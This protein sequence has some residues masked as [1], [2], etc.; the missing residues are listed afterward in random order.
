MV[1][2]AGSSIISAL[3][4]GSG[5]N[6]TSLVAD[7][8]SA[9]RGPKQTAI[10]DKQSLNNA[11]VSAMASAISSMSTFSTTLSTMLKDPTYTG[12]PASA[13]PSIV[14]VS[15]LST[16]KPAGLPA[17]I[18]VQQLAQAQVLKS[19]TLA[20]SGTA[21]GQGS[22]TLTTA[23]GAHKITIGEGNDSLAG[24]AQAI[25][26]SGAG[27]T[28]TVMSDASGSRLVLKGATGA[29]NSFT[30]T[31]EA[32]DTASAD[33]ERFT[34]GSGSNG[35]MASTQDARNAIIRLDGVEMQFA[36]NTVKE[37]LPNVQID[38]NKAAPGTKVALGM[39]T[40]AT[41]IQDMLKDFVSGYNSMRGALNSV[42]AGGQNASA[43]GALAGD[44]SIREM[45]S[46]LSELTTTELLSDG[47]YKSLSDIGVKTNR[48]GTLTLDTDRLKAV[49]ETS[50][51]IVERMINPATSTDDNPGLA[52]IVTDVNDRLQGKDGALTVAK[53]KYDALT[54]SYA[55]QME[56]LNTQMENYEE[57]MTAVYARLGT[58][59]NT[60]K[61]TQS[62]MEQQISVWTNKE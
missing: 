22:L 19:E 37:A 53:A 55:E 30:L 12:K 23:S 32:D 28:A 1:S 16:G 17:Q 39:D 42:S 35:T 60:I 36:T 48:D 44:S 20:T 38:L 56:K 24:L 26:D 58:Q 5:L 9:A 51:D 14:S 43:T 29:D 7:L 52:K 47:P 54:K 34:F 59:L 57:R 46:R 2:S 4:G 40:P 11:R 18:E 50:P 21:V 10:T 62:Y 25:N 61:A 49:M 6:T 3:G 8:V 27:V 41:S 31:K 33:L 13:D 45:K 15:T